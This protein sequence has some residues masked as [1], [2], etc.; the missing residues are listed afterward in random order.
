MIQ[1]IILVMDVVKYKTL[2]SGTPE[3]LSW[4]LLKSLKNNCQFNAKYDQ[5][6]IGFQIYV[7]KME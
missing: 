6:I 4:L 3:W 1:N 5:C 7:K 2:P